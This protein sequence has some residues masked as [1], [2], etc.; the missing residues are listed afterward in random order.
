MS[1]SGEIRWP[2]MGRFS[3]P[4]SEQ[5]RIRGR[6]GFSQEEVGLRA[7]LHRTEI[8]LLERG[9]R[10]ACID[11]LLKLAG[12]SASNS[13][14]RFWRASSG[15][16]AACSAGPSRYRPTSLGVGTRGEQ[17]APLPTATGI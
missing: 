4:P 9:E 2:S 1:A 13:R 10:L 8:G 14:G 5:R 3:W 12:R 16:R 17:D 11:T 7:G 15:S 6:I